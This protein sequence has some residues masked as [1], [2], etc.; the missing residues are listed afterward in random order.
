MYEFKL[1]LNGPEPLRYPSVQITHA[2][3][4]KARAMQVLTAVES[5]R[6]K[7]RF[8][9]YYNRGKRFIHSIIS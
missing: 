8:E 1:K 9:R 5:A 7:L 4:D 3:V 6:V 2:V